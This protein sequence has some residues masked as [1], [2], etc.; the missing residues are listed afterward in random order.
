MSVLLA[1]L[2]YF[3]YV[4]IVAMYS[5]K[6]VK[7]ARMPVHLRW[8]LYPVASEKESKYGGSYY[9]DVE[10]WKK[11]KAKPPALIKKWWETVGDF[12]FP[13]QVKNG[14]ATF[15]RPDGEIVRATFKATF[16]K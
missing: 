1:I 3:A 14:V 10:Q 11:M 6:L 15:Q 13:I 16:P 8:E 4:F 12:A 9:G 5:V 7:I 2:T